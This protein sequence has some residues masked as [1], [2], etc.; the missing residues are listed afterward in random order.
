MYADNIKIKNYKSNIIDITSHDIIAITNKNINNGINEIS[1]AK[2]FVSISKNSVYVNPKINSNTNILPDIFE[3]NNNNENYNINTQIQ[4][5]TKF[6]VYELN[7]TSGKYSAD[8][9]VKYMLVRAR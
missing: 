2:R 8:S 3:L 9:I 6:P 1:F 4:E 5:A 7:M